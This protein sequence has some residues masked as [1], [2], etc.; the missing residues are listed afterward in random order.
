[1][2]L[3][4]EAVINDVHMF[5]ENDEQQTPKADSV[6]RIQLNIDDASKYKKPGKVGETPKGQAP[7]KGQKPQQGQESQKGDPPKKGQELK[8]KNENKTEQ[9]EEQQT[10]ATENQQTPEPVTNTKPAPA[11]VQSGEREG[12]TSTNDEDSKDKNKPIEG[13][14]DA[15]KDSAIM[16]AGSFLLA[17]V[18]FQ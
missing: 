8:G 12:G 4:K 18:I 11:E 5:H 17:F 6:I 14:G 7:Q 15:S 3:L 10:K 16:I 1:M 9:G 13:S 2:S